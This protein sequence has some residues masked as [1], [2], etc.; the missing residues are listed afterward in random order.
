MLFCLKP[1]FLMCNL[2][3]QIAGN[4]SGIAAFQMDIKVVMTIYLEAFVMYFCY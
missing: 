2:L 1:S 4:E 3:F